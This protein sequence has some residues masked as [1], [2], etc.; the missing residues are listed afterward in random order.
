MDFP[1]LQNARGI[2]KNIRISFTWHCIGFHLD[3]QMEKVIHKYYF[4]FITVKMN[5]RTN[6]NPR[7]PPN[8][9]QRSTVLPYSSVKTKIEPRMP[10]EK[11][12]QCAQRTSNILP[13]KMLCMSTF[14]L[15]KW[16]VQHVR[17]R[18]SKLMYYLPHKIN[19]FY[20]IVQ[21]FAFRI[22]AWYSFEPQT[23]TAKRTKKNQIWITNR[24]DARFNIWYSILVSYKQHKI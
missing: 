4:N 24:N 16:W 9:H 18:K 15:G 19:F 3:Y 13:H 2:K 1:S 23:Q 5:Q 6:D 12:V 17:L 20:F 14:Y 10:I 7:R 22:D 8:K 11:T 21:C